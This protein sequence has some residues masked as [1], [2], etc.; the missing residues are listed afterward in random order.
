M[1]MSANRLAI[2]LVAFAFILAACTEEQATPVSQVTPISQAERPPVSIPLDSANLALGNANWMAGLEKKAEWIWSGHLIPQGFENNLGKFFLHI[3]AVFEEQLDFS[4]TLIF[5]EP[6]FR[7]G[8]QMSGFVDRVTRELVISY[9]AQR[10]RCW[11]SMTHHALLGTITARKHGLTDDAIAAKW[12][13]LLEYQSHSQDYTRLERAALRFAEAFATNTKSYTDADYQELRAAFR[14]EN[15]R[16]FADESGWLAKLGAAR[17]AHTYALGTGSSAEQASR[18]ALKAQQSA[19]A[20]ISEQENERKIDAQVVELA[21]LAAQF[22]ALTDMFTALNIPDEEGLADVMVEQVPP[23]VIAVINELNKRGGEGLNGLLPPSVDLPLEAILAGRVRVES[24]PLRGTRVPLTSF[25][26]DPTLGTRDKGVAVGAVQVG[27]YGWANGQFFPGGLGALVLNHPELARHEPPYSLPLLFNE[28]E[29]RNGTNTSG[30]IDRRFKE[31]AL[32]KVYRLTRNRYGVEHHTMFLFN[33]YVR[34]YG[35][36]PYRHPDF[37]DEQAAAAMQRATDAFQNAILHLREHDK[38]PE[39]FGEF[40]RALFSWIEAVVRRPHSAYRLEPALR[41][42]L[43]RQNR[44]EVKAG[45]RRLDRTPDLD[46]DGAFKRLLNHQVA[47]LAMLVGHMD[48]LGRVLSILRTEGES[49]TQIAAGTIN[50]DGSLT[51][52]LDEQGR[53]Q[54]TGYYSNRPDFLVLLRILGI[55]EEVL[56]ANELLLNP[57]LNEKVKAQLAA[58]QSEIRIPVAEALETGEF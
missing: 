58:G 50:A 34:Q 35:A 49:A 19:N 42:A 37:N 25:E 38:H 27:S 15:D 40:E 24:A 21:F 28:D 8:E 57:R 45:I 32:Q 12:S 17:A 46:E 56:T 16:R 43:D 5:D 52:A 18:Q 14:E 30:F 44:E 55:P 39:H 22:V 54:L 4:T 47:E 3:P 33:E 23:S 20:G 31:L 13:H 41:S 11:Y 2:S 1:M 51:P 7:N 36:G 26:A 10:R 6:S 48:G 9:I 53:L 29:Y